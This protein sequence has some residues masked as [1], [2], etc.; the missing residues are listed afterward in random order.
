MGEPGGLPSMGL[1]RVGHNWSDLA[2][3]YVHN[4]CLCP[5]SEPCPTPAS[6]GDLARLE[7]RCGPSSY[8]ITAFSLFLV[9][10]SFFCMPFKSKVSFPP[11]LWSSCSQSLPAFK[12]NCSGGS[13]SLCQIPW[14][15]GLTWG[16]E[17]SVLWKNLCNTI[18]SS[19]WVAHWGIRGLIILQGHPSY[20]SHCVSFFMSLVV[21]D[22][23]W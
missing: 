6:P 12:V 5:Q 22:L 14:L 18:F 19:L 3:A 7:G 15:G 1:H 20:L 10:V 2:A 11:I 23:F 16:S 17:L 13:S 8:E 9:H 21:K 4:Q